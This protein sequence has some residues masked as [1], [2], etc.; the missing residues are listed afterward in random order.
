M[1]D[2]AL[3]IPLTKLMLGGLLKSD[4]SRGTWIKVLHVALDCAALTGSIAAFADDNDFLAGLLDPVLNLEKLYLQFRFVLLID[5]LS[6]LAEDCFPDSF[7]GLASTGRNGG[8]PS[9]FAV[10]SLINKPL[11]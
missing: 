1:L 3:E 9:A 6:D 8:L 4:N 11:S 5:G 7:L 2:V 10:P